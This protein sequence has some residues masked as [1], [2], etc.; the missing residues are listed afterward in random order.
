MREP[1]NAKK[2]Q[3]TWTDWNPVFLF[4]YVFVGGT[5]KEGT[6]KREREREDKG[7]RVG[8]GADDTVEC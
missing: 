5:D 2:Q 1:L 7:G 8:G 3:K 4:F 6:K